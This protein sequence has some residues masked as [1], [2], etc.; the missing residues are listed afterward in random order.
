MTRLRWRVVVRSGG[1]PDQSRSQGH[2]SWHLADCANPLASDT[3]CAVGRDLLD[4][5]ADPD[6]H[7]LID[8]DC[9]RCAAIMVTPQTPAVMDEQPRG[10]RRSRA[11]AN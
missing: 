9:P 11:P 4:S 8:G 7:C 2:L 1:G 6:G 10:T 5:G 3:H